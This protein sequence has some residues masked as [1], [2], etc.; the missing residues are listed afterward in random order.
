M[1]PTLKSYIFLKEIAR[2]PFGEVQKVRKGNDQICVLKKIQKEVGKDGDAEFFQTL[3]HENIVKIL[4]MIDFENHIYIAMELCDEGNLSQYF[5]NKKTHLNERYSMMVE[6]AE[7][8][9][10]L[11]SQHVIHRF[12]KP[13]NILLRKHGEMVICK[14]SDYIM[15]SIKTARKDWYNSDIYNPGYIAP[16]V[17]DGKVITSSIDVF[18]LGLIYFAIFHGS[19]LKDR[20]ARKALI[21][22]RYDYDGTIEYLN[23][24]L[25]NKKPSEM[26]FLDDYFLQP[27]T[28]GR[29]LGSLMYCMLNS[30][31][32]L[33]PQMQT[34]LTQVNFA[35]KLEE[36]KNSLQMKVDMKEAN[37]QSL[38]GDLNSKDRHLMNV[39][40]Q[41][42]TFS[43]TKDGETKLLLEQLETK[44]LELETMSRQ[45]H[46]SRLMKSWVM[47][48]AKGVIIC[49]IVML[50][51]LLVYLSVNRKED[52]AVKNMHE[53]T[54]TELTS[55]IKELEAN[56]QLIE[57]QMQKQS[58]LLSKSN[59]DIKRENLRLAGANLLLKEVYNN[60]FV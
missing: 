10:Y 50:V 59:M 43:F 30:E 54:V 51:A 40:S 60:N 56:I 53:H 55:R 58:H 37:L 44:N 21:P 5:I 7:G 16:E 42:E 32:D 11:H 13:E 41:L 14:I 6:L 36:E 39:Q 25:K 34:V 27:D 18:N 48:T 35:K 31:P 29:F 15:S 28:T 4:E 17:Q 1:K 47:Q 2:G 57:N 33:R 24:T 20:A 3:K 22:G 38:K 12:L 52:H 9:K 8:L 49:F 23:G 45:L 46:D 19:V 26:Q